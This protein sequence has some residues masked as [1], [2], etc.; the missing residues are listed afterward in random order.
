LTSNPLVSGRCGTGATV[1]GTGHTGATMGIGTPA[2]PAPLWGIG[3]GLTG[4]TMGIGIGLTTAA[5][6]MVTA[7]MVTAGMGIAAGS[8]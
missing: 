2:I 1:I 4:A 5:G 3:T 7:T 6:F 8:Q